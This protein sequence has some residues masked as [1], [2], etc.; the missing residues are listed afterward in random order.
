M[1]TYIRTSAIWTHHEFSPALILSRRVEQS[2]QAVSAW[3]NTFDQYSLIITTDSHPP[4]DLDLSTK[5][6]SVEPVKLWL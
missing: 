3:E 5:E 6:F 4:I 1:W 2:C